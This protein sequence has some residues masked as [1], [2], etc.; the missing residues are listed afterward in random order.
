M[1][2]STDHIYHGTRGSVGVDTS[3]EAAIADYLSGVTNKTQR[4][5]LI[6]AK[7]AGRRGIT[8]ADVREKTGGLHHGRM[9]SAVTKQHIAGNLVR[10]TE[11]RGNAHVYVLPEFADGRELHPYR[12]QGRRFS[13]DDIDSVAEILAEEF[14]AAPRGIRLRVAE[15]IIYKLGAPA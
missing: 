1:S 9:S 6:A 10:L 7:Q 4:Y 8:V 13:Q 14:S 2:E 3:Q 11:R 15:D 12:R 5:V